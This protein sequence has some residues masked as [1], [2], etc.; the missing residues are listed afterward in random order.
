MP[1][2]EADPLA[3]YW[4]KRDFSRTSEPRGQHV[5]AGAQAL[6]FVIQKHAATRL[7]YDFRLEL[8]GV[9]LCWAVPK[10]PSYDPTDKRMAIHVEDHPLSYGSFEGTIPPKQYGAGTVIVWDNGTWEPVGDP[11]EGL[12]KGKLVFH[13]HGQKMEGLWELVKIAKGGERQEPW[14]LFKKRDAFARPR[15]EYDVVSALPDSVIAKPLKP[16]AARGVDA[17]IPSRAKT[18]R[19]TAGKK[20][21]EAPVPGAVKAALPERLT[22]Q[23]ATLA[24]GVPSSGRWLYEIKFDGYRLLAR[25]DAGKAALITRNGHDWTS[26]MPGLAREIE[27]LGLKSGWLDGEIVVFGSDGLPSFN[28]LQKAL[29]SRVAKADIVYFLFDLPFLEGYDLR[30][31]ELVARRQLL[32]ALLDEHGSEH[33]R[34]SADFEADPASILDSAAR[35][36]L[37]GV[38]AK[39]ADA[40]YSSRRTDTWLKLKCRL[41]QE[42]VI[43]GYTENSEDPARVG[44]LLLGVHDAHGALLSVG[45]VGTGWSVEE[46]K[47][48]KQK[49]AQSKRTQPPFPAGAPEAGRWSKRTLGS[50]KWIEP[51]LVAEVEFA[52][53]TPDGQIRHASFVSLRSDK[54]AAAVMRE[55]ARPLA[56]NGPVRSP[57][58]TVIGDIQ[59]SNADRVIDAST[60]LTKLDLARYYASVAE[61]M[62]PHVAGRPCSF[63]RGPDGVGGQLFFQKHGEKIGIPGVRELD[64]A[65]WPGHQALLEVATAQ[66][67]LGAAQMNVIEFHTWNSRARTIDKPD[68]MVFDLDPGEGTAWPQVQEAAVLVRTLLTELGLAAWVK[69]SGG[70]GMHVVV[71]IAPRYDYDTVKAF[72]L[73]VAQH[74]ARVIPSR[75]VARSGAANRVGKLFVDYLRNGHGAT[76]VAAFSARARPGLGVSMPVAWEDVPKLKSGAQWNI[77]T[78]REHLSFQ[79]ADPWAGY[80]KCRQPLAAAM[81]LLDFRPKA[82]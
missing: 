77:A 45:G 56:G 80:W 73:A 50:E 38:I 5:A 12:A 27:K 32:Q 36:N 29:E 69:T 70:K 64:P 11:R 71:P 21:Q 48:L 1:A 24:T 23:L 18:R 52:A 61:W 65:L 9:L 66:A 35:M 47:Q 53:W 6:S 74:L 20:A 44:S 67:L 42:F 55:T 14:I 79:T 16:P 19:S 41:R 72:S 13:L 3:R 4:A 63:V 54:P 81:K 39:R 28:A 76:T 59:V 7:H 2:R 25:I 17:A 58:R 57:G 22:P 49:L 51:R 75:F 62:L 37:E 26:K 60:G 30:G 8:D 33:L 40:P 34:F 31:V 43:C 82:G 78:A 68:R 46:A 10:G 15:S